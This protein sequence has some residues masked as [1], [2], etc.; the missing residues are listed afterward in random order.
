M[1]IVSKKHVNNKT[2]FLR[3]LW[4]WPGDDGCISFVLEFYFLE[5]IFV[6]VEGIF[7]ILPE[8]CCTWWS[9]P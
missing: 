2:D 6:L 9:H 8:K 7:R 5:G 3:A 4:P 1:Y